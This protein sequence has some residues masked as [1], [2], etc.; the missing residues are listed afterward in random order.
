[1]AVGSEIAIVSNIGPLEI[2][3]DTLFWCGFQIG[4]TYIII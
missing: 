2:I 3:M 4:E 1:M